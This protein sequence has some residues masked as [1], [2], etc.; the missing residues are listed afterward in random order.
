[1]VATSRSGGALDAYGELKGS[2]IYTIYMD[3]RQGVAVMQFSDRSVSQ[4]FE[5]DLTAPEPV[6]YE[7]PADLPKARLVIACEMDRSGLLHHMRVLQAASNEL[8]SRFM[9]A[10]HGWRFRPVLRGSEAIEV[11][12][13]LGFNIDTR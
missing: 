7:L 9:T 12:A 1:V 5:A 8:A 3:T 6:R 11:D 10:L 4:G 2:R 13:I